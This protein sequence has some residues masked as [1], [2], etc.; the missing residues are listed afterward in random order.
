[1]D[2]SGPSLKHFSCFSEVIAVASVQ[3]TGKRTRVSPERTRVFMEQTGQ[4][5]EKLKEVMTLREAS[6]YLGISPDTLYKY[7]G[8][9]SIPAFKL[10]NRWR[11][12]KDLLDRWIERKIERTELVMESKPK[13]LVKS[14]IK[15]LG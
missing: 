11:F 2:I 8:E 7:L 6:Q 4:K 5:M 14:T 9:K 13:R 12:K 15:R 1:V 10:G 3:K